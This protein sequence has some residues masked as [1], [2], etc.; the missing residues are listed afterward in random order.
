[1]SERK[2][3]RTIRRGDEFM[4]LWDDGAISRPS[5]PAPYD[6]PSGKWTLTGAVELNNFGYIVRRWSL[7]D[8]LADPA[9]IPWRHK[10]GKQ[11]VH[12]ADLDH[13]MRRMWADSG[14]T[15]EIF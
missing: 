13:G 5:C 12:V 9:A 15:H 4:K 1:M 6:Q 3:A 2:P 7:A 10:N 11:R 14:L 8:V